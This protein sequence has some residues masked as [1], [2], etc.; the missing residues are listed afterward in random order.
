MEKEIK[1][2]VTLLEMN[3]MTNDEKLKR[4]DFFVEADGFATHKLWAE[5][6]YNNKQSDRLE[7]VQDSSGFSRVIGNIGKGAN[8]PVNI[9]CHFYAIGDKYVCFYSSTLRFVDWTMVEEYIDK[10]FPVKYDSN[11]RRARVDANNF[12]NC[13]HFCQ[14]SI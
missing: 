1:T 8:R 6:F 13:Y 11:L 5:Y 9:D 2:P 14:D 3:R 7:W 12:H 10:N 4:V